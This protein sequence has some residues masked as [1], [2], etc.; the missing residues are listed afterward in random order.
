MRNGKKSF[1]KNPSKSTKK[2]AEKALH[3]VKKI[4]GAIETKYTSVSDTGTSTA[5]WQLLFTDA[6]NVAQ[7]DTNITR[8]GN[9]ITTTSIDWRFFIEAGSLDPGHMRV[10]LFLWNSD[11]DPVVPDPFIS[12]GILVYKDP[13]FNGKCKILYD[14]FHYVGPDAPV[15]KMV[16]KFFKVRKTL[17]YDGTTAVTPEKWKLCCAY[18][19]E[20][21]S[22][23]F[24]VLTSVC[25]INFVDL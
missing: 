8:T 18:I 7:G 5:A 11:S 16:H 6:L 19:G 14:K 12:D 23:N 17:M 10:V 4:K 25:K 20:A 21:Y 15:A 2:I 22:T 9:K 24:P 13:I 1:Y 3:E